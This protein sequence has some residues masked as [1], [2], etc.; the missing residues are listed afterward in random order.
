[1]MKSIFRKWVW[2]MA[3]R[4]ARRGLKPLLDPYFEPT[5]AKLRMAACAVG[6]SDRVDLARAIRAALLRGAVQPGAASNPF[7]GAPKQMT[8]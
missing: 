8:S 5:P 1:M 4:D 6:I 7:L 3:L 2:S